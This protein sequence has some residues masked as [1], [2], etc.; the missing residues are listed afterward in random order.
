M[1]LAFSFHVHVYHDGAVVQGD[2]PGKAEGV[3][4]EL[5]PTAPDH[6][7]VATGKLRFYAE[8]GHSTAHDLQ[9]AAHVVFPAGQHKAE[10]QVAHVVKHRAAAAAAPGQAAALILQQLHPT[11]LPGVLVPPDDH[12]VPVLP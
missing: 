8:A 6:Q 5:R 11:L 4:G 9:L 7:V 10:V 12:G 1:P 3:A 2:I